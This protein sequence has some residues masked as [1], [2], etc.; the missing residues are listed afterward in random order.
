VS[1]INEINGDPLLSRFMK[2]NHIRFADNYF[3]INGPTGAA[4]KFANF[5]KST[6]VQEFVNPE[7]VEALLV[8][9]DIA[10]AENKPRT[11]P[12]IASD[13]RQLNSASKNIDS[14][15]RL[16]EFKRLVDAFF[17]KKFAGEIGNGFRLDLD[18]RNAARQKDVNKT[19]VIFD[20]F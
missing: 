5:E 7:S 19:I 2:E 17:S 18:S 10:S 20:P 13:P 8:K 12:A 9:K 1:A 6:L 11:N 14:D 15:P 4:G 3:A 16:D